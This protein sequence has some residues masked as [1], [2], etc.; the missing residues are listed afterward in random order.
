[1]IKKVYQVRVNMKTQFHISSGVMES[2]FIKNYIVKKNHTAYIPASTIKG[3]VRNNFK[4]LLGTKMEEQEVE[5]IVSLIFGGE[6]YQ[7]AKIY[8]EDLMPEKQTD[9][10]IRYGVAIDRYKRVFKDQAL[11]NYEVAETGEYS[12]KVLIYF[13]DI[14][15]QYEE[16]LKMA[17]LM[18]NAIG[19]GRSRGLGHCK[20]SIEEAVS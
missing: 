19:K 8:F 3:K 11:Y 16:D 13:D 20:T 12:G 6:G 14:S 10:S 5:R 4:M 9:V 1:M 18:V 7:P 17:F 15:I 2:G